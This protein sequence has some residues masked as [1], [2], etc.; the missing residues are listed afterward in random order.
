MLPLPVT[1]ADGG[2]EVLAL[3]AHCDDVEIGAGGT[4]LR[5]AEDVPGLRLH[6]AVLTSTPARAAEA[7]ASAKAF[8]APAEV[9]TEVHALPDGRLPAHWG[10]VKDVLEDLAARTRP[11]VVLCP[12]RHDAHQDHALLGSLVTTAFRD[13]LVLRYEVPKWDGDLGAT[14]PTCYVPLS[15]AQLDRK[16][17]LLAE[18][19]PSQHGRDW[20]GDE[21]FRALAR[22]RGMECRAPYAEAFAADALVLSPG[23]GRTAPRSDR[24]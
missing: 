19:F 6:V 11:D 10:E 7:H 4:L 13:H 21:T 9:S 17:T 15:P 3:G 2:L 20:F 18:C 16:C 12:T 23:R 14:R 24:G 1:G 5:L 22:L 8:G